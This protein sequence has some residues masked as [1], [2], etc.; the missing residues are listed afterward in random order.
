MGLSRYVVLGSAVVGSR[1]CCARWAASPPDPPTGL[2]D[3]AA[4]PV[5]DPADDV[6]V[7]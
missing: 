5:G 3:P 1:S 7:R 4:D 6:R 2:A